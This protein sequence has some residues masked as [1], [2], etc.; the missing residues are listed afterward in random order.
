MLFIDMRRYLYLGLAVMLIISI[1][2]CGNPKP[3]T[4]KYGLLLDSL[5]SEYA[6]VDS[7]T[8]EDME[9]QSSLNDASSRWRINYSNSIDKEYSDLISRMPEYKEQL[10]KDCNAWLAYQEAVSNVAQKSMDNGSSTRMFI[11]D[12][13][14]Q[15][16]KLRELS[17]GGLLLHAKKRNV[18]FCSTMFTD[19]MIEKAYSVWYDKENVESDDY[20]KKEVI[21]SFLSALNDEKQ[22]FS[23][24]MNVRAEISSSL[25][26]DIK[27]L[28]DGCTNEV[29][30]EKLLQL[31]NQN[32]G[33][34]M[35]IN[36]TLECILPSCCSDE[37]LLEYPGFNVVME[38]H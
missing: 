15:G 33:N 11:N 17:I 23:D 1:S 29:M 27:E 26:T 38:K 9:S 10:Q 36:E 3:H 6:C 5:Y 37:E 24:W 21:E 20:Y 19:D 31:K 2:G 28:F 8:D 35:R 13:L 32:Q 22:K 30:R 25:P 34:G 7:L 4:E 14:C 16:I 12:V 18:V